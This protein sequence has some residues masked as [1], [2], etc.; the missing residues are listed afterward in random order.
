MINFLNRKSKVFCIGQNKTGTTSMGELL[1]SLGYKLAP[2]E[3]AEMMIDDWAKRDFSKIIKFCKKYDAFQDI[4]FSLPYT[5]QALDQAFPGSKF[6]LTIRSSSQEWFESYVRFTKKRFNITHFPTMRDLQNDTYRYKGFTE[7]VIKLIYGENTPL[8]D[9]Q[10]YKTFYTQYNED[11]VNYF[12]F[13]KNDLLVT[14]LAHPSAEA[15]IK[16]FLHISQHVK[17]LLPHLNASQ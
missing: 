3:P 15:D 11:A 1:R 16:N 2:Q 12:A 9:E 5:Y 17:T 6:I 8:F 10:A 14:N 13:R 4:P 7:R